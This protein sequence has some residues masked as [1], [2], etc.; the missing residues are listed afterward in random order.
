MNNRIK[1]ICKSF[2]PIL[3]SALSLFIVYQILQ[4]LA[5]Y[6]DPEWTLRSSRGLGKVVFVSMVIYQVILLI[7]IQPRVFLKKFFETNLYFFAER[8]WFRKYLSFFSLFFILHMFV[9]LGFYL[10]GYAYFDFQGISITFSLIYKILFGFFVAFMLAW[11]EELIF[12]GALFPYFEKTFSTF[13][14]LVITTFIFMFAHNVGAPWKM[15]TDNLAIGIGLFL[16]GFLLNVVFAVSRKLYIGMG[17]H[18]GLVAVKVF[19]RRVPCLNFVDSSVCSW[20]VN[21]DLRQSVIIHFLFLLL[22]LYLVFR[23]RNRLFQSA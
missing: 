13:T 19:F 16:L 3:L 15:V 23:Y 6:M 1:Q 8:G 22:I 7:S 4:P 9:I 21:S 18:S 20:L 10:T 17:I 2:G 14:S 5:V 12:R 11:T